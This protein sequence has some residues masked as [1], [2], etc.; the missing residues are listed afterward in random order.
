MF[1]GNIPN[2]N[3]HTYFQ[4]DYKSFNCTRNKLL[5]QAWD[6][7]QALALKSRKR[8]SRFFFG[9]ETRPVS[10][11]PVLLALLD[12]DSLFPLLAIIP[13]A[14]EVIAFVTGLRLFGWPREMLATWLGRASR[15]LDKSPMLGCV[16]VPRRQLRVLAVNCGWWS[17]GVANSSVLKVSSDGMMFARGRR[18]PHFL[19]FS[20]FKT[21]CR[22]ECK[23]EQELSESDA[24]RIHPKAKHSPSRNNFKLIAIS[25]GCL[26][27]SRLAW[28]SIWVNNWMLTYF[29]QVIKSAE[30]NGVVA[31]C[32]P[33]CLR[34]SATLQNYKV[35]TM[36]ETLQSSVQDRI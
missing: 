25:N 33:C 10:S 34:Q 1:Q 9:F 5:F 18:S 26:F 15:P 20:T 4:A 13:A 14:A 17:E 12:G 24:S 19:F 6:A 22:T 35:V 31:P 29:L 8:F 21:F 30:T 27:S 11:S 36:V 7:F 23:N 16:T 28:F 2:K 3:I 32:T